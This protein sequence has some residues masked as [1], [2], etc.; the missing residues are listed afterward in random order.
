MSFSPGN[1]GE[2]FKSSPKM[3]PTAQRST[4]SVYFLAPYNSSGAL[5]HLV[6]TYHKKN[7]RIFKFITLFTAG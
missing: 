3:H 4:P 1:N 5:Y 7:I 6:A 2:K